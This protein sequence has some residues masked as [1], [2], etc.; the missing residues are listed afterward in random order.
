[1]TMAPGGHFLRRETRP[2]DVFVKKI[3]A[4]AS[5]WHGAIGR[6]VAALGA[7]NNS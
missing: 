4:L 6:Q 5:A 3:A 7:D 1:M 2:A